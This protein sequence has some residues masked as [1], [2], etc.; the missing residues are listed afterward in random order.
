[1]IPTTR[2]LRRSEGFPSADHRLDNGCR[3]RRRR[4]AG[5]DGGFALL[6]RVGVFREIVGH[7]NGFLNE[8]RERRMYFEQFV[9][10]SSFARAHTRS[11]LLINSYITDTNTC[12]FSLRWR[13]N[14]MIAK[15]KESVE[16]VEME[17]D[18]WKNRCRDT[19]QQSRDA[20]VAWLVATGGRWNLQAML[21]W[22]WY[23]SPN[24]D[25]ASFSLSLSRSRSA[26][27]SL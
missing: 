9:S 23:G 18:E 12:S 11:H 19:D 27:F 8:H 5:L 2:T 4:I 14:Q 17:K 1:M 15:K 22:C 10:L 21:L 24:D 3:R 6:V 16:Q 20:K 26:F 7:G 13:C 25:D